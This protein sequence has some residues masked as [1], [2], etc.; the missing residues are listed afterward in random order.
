[1]KVAKKMLGIHTNK[2]PSKAETAAE[3]FHVKRRMSAINS[4]VISWHARNFVIAIFS[5]LDATFFL[6]QIARMHQPRSSF[7]STDS[8]GEYKG[9]YLSAQWN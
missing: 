3:S 4:N 9:F 1:M 2:P 7:L 6:I 8:R 5:L